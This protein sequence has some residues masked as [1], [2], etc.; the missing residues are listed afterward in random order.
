MMKNSSAVPQVLHHFPNKEVPNKKG[1]II[2]YLYINLINKQTKIVDNTIFLDID[3][4]A[5]FR[6]YIN[7]FFFLSFLIQTKDP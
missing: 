6:I 1:I 7:L 4:T 5:Y 3:Y 2:F